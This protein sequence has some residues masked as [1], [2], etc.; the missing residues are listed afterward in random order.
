MKRLAPRRLDAGPVLGR[1][2]ADDVPDG[3]GDD[4]GKA[5]RLSF[6]DQHADGPGAFQGVPE[7][8]AALEEV[9]GVVVRANRRGYE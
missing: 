2:V 5:H 4:L 1:V 6:S 8:L 3:P 7:R 9:G